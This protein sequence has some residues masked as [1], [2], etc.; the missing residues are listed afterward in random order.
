MRGVFLVIEPYLNFNGNCNE[1]IEFYEKVFNGTEKKIMFYKDLPP[2]SEYPIPEEMK[3]LVL[4]AEMT[5]SATKVNFSDMK[6]HVIPGNMI[7]FAVRFATQDEV[8]SSFNQLKEG[9]EVLMELGQ[10]F[11]SPMYGWIK[12]KYGV[13]WQLIC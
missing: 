10:Q 5:I 3:E 7:S 4:H 6:E 1:A 11:F 2:N 8:I 13:G 12:D 9:G